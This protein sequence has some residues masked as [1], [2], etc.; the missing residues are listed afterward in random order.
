MNDLD[1]EWL[2]WAGAI[3]LFIMLAFGTFILFRYPLGKQAS[4]SRHIASN[5]WHYLL[6]ALLLTIGGGIFYGF[7]IFWLVPT[8]HISPVIYGLLAIAFIAQLTLAWVPDKLPTTPS[9]RRLHLLHFTGGV[10]VAVIMMLSLYFLC[11]SYEYLPIISSFFVIASTIF[12]TVCIALYTFVRRS[13]Q[14]FLW[15]ECVFILLFSAAM[16]SLIFKI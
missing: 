4:I 1:F 3:I 8:Y 15:L 2:R 6:M 5:P 9:N 7:L 10:I 16:F 12:S 13:R 14:Y 11:A